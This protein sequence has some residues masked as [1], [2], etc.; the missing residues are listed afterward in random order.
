MMSSEEKAYYMLSKELSLNAKKYL[1]PK[2][3]VKNIGGK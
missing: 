1:N 2:Y 3:E